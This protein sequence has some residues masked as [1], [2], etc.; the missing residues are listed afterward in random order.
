IEIAAWGYAGF[1]LLIVAN[2]I[3]NA[4]DRASFALTQS[5]CR[6]FLV[7]LPFALFLDQSWGSSAI[8]AAELAANIFGAVTAVVLIWLVLGRSVK[9]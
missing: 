7:M 4:V 5:I 1:G 8:Y 6:V 9:R 3:L 2:G